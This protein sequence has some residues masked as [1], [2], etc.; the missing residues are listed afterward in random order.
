[1][2]KRP[3][4][5]FLLIMVEQLCRLGRRTQYAVNRG[6]IMKRLFCT[7]TLL[8]S[9]GLNAQT[10]APPPATP[11]APGL[12]ASPAGRGLPS[13]PQTPGLPGFTGQPPIV[14]PTNAFS[15]LTFTNQFGTN[16]TGGD[17]AAAL[18][19]LQ[20]DLQNALP[21]IAAFNGGFQSTAVTTPTTGVN[22]SQ[23]LGGNA[24]ANLGANASVNLAT[25]AGG[26][27]T[28]TTSPNIP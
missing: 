22:L 28:T 1:M 2:E 25:P 23:N 7:V 11:T 27:A 10:P 20:N 13:S 15:N 12:P 17:L 4:R 8:F 3:L 16:F 5:A 26:V 18:A 24:G 19:V 9:V 14:L 6:T 21:L